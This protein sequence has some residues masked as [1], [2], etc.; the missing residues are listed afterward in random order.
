MIVSK[1][2]HLKLVLGLNITPRSFVSDHVV[3][4]ESVDPSFVV[5]ACWK[6]ALEALW[7]EW[8]DHE[9]R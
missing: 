2:I 6:L 7:M 4:G 8:T 1:T 9:H 5:L 3:W